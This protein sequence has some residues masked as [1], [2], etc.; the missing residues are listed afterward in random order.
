MTYALREPLTMRNAANC[1]WTDTSRGMSCEAESPERSVLVHW[2]W[3]LQ[4]RY[5]LHCFVHDA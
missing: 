4:W 5:I 1:A 2:S 3:E